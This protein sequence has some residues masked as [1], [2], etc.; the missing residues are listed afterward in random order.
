M[1]NP[2]AP[3]GSAPV[4]PLEAAP[5]DALERELYW[6]APPGTGSAQAVFASTPA[7][8]LAVMWKELED[9]LRFEYTQVYPP[10][11]ETVEVGGGGKRF[12]KRIV[13]RVIRPLIR[14]YDRLGA[15][16]AELG[17]DTAQSIAGT[18]RDLAQVVE[19]LQSIAAEVRGLRTD[20]RSL[21][22]GEGLAARPGE[23]AE[24]LPDAFH[25]RFDAAMRGSAAS[26]TERLG[27]Y[28]GLAADLHASVDDEPLWLDL[29]CG[30]GHFLRL[31]GVWGWRA[32]GVDVHVAA[33]EA[34]RAAGLEA[35]PGRLPGYLAGYDDEAPTA[36]SMIQVIEHLPTATWLTV[37]AEAHRVL[38][39]GGLLLVETLDPRNPTSLQWYF[40]DVRHTWL[41]HPE[42]LR[43]MAEVA[44]FASTEI[45][46]LNPDDGGVPQDFALVARKA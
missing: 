31:L 9:R 40:G 28:E 39:S 36:I 37:L 33:V 3:E 43:V 15:D 32:R 22:T 20:V 2:D 16:T 11:E 7:S 19:Q 6:A 17:F 21:Q 29:G 18:Q 44:G 30:D 27:T 1:T 4:D 38:A 35:D 12:V 41:A 45:L 25:E 24:D 8:E 14:R 34:C 42:T 23:T 46:G 26:V 13:H 5:A 10:D